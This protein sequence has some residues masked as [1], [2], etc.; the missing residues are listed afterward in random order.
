MS[1]EN[2]KTL[3]VYDKYADAYL[4]TV[5]R[6][7]QSDPEK[8]QK[9]RENLRRFFKESFGPL[10][11]R[12]KIFEI[13]SGDGENAKCLEELNYTVVASDVS[14]GFIETVQELGMACRKFNVLT[15]KFD[16]KYDGFLAWRVFVHFTK[17]DLKL[18]LQKI[19]D[20]LRPGGIFVFNVL[21]TIDH[22]NKDGAWVDF[23]GG[24]HMGVERYFNYYREED[25]DQFI[26]DAGFAIQNKNY[27]GGDTGKRWIIYVVKKP[28]GIKPEIEDYIENEILP[29]YS[30]LQ[31]HTNDH[32][33]QVIAHSLA[34]VEDMPEVNRD[35]SYVIAA[36]HDLGRLIDDETHNI[37]SGKLI[38]KDKKLRESFS[39][40]EIKTMIEAVEDHRASIKG[41]PRSIYGKIV[42][43][44]DRDMDL[45]E[46]LK[47]SYDY[48]RHLH[49]EM[50][51]DGAIE[52]ARYHLRI[53][54]SPDGY[55]AKK[56]YFPTP[57]R[58]ACYRK[59][60]EITRD[61]LE[62]RRIMKEFNKKRGIV[63]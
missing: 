1:I 35:M 23:E 17:E 11:P 57:D 18:A 37:E 2:E 13:G 24:Y 32:I 19:Y 7:R 61:P 45:Y 44:A 10:P 20:S 52:E 6:H 26:T 21:N 55:G 3:E 53:K 63:A 16:E 47:R 40:E 62:Y 14:N 5:E 56:D 34:L 9:K 59:I 51:D 39:E 36:Y 33:R 42:G 30:K 48:A 29:Q 43:S 15:D 4:K 28:T 31:G 27:E 60:E 38:A 8:A 46:M 50:T 49:P 54:F 58:I 12:N 22:D 41:E 25:A